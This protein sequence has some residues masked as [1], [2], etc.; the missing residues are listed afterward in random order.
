M[1]RQSI[2]Y[3]ILALVGLALALPGFAD[4]SSVRSKIQQAYAKSTKAASLKFLDGMLAVRSPDFKAYDKSGK[5]ID[6]T[7]ELAAFQSLLGQALTVTETV[8]ILS[9]ELTGENTAECRIQDVFRWT[10]VEGK[11]RAE[12]TFT[13]RTKSEDGWKLTGDGW[14]QSTTRVLEQTVEKKDVSKP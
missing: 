8:E 2:T 12:V 6:R 9:F 13:L 11:E 4:S 10:A 14:K 7:E 3:F 5:V 1:R